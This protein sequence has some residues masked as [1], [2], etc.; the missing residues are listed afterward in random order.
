[1]SETFRC[2]DKEML[3]AY[4]YGEIDADG[5]REV[6]RH[7]RSC[8]TCAQEL[9]GLQ[10][11]R[12]DLEGWQPPQADLGFTIV[13]KP[14][15]M[16]RPSRWSSIG[17]MPAWAQAA[18]AVLVLAVGAAVA[19]IQVRYGTDGVTVTTG[20][21]RAP[22]TPA[23][24]LQAAPVPTEDWRPALAA[25]GSEL[26]G[27]IARMQRTGARQPVAVRTAVPTALSD[28]AILKRVQALLD[29]SEQRQRQEFALR[30]S[31][32]RREV[33]MNRQADLMRIDRSFGNLQGQTFKV[34]EGQRE[35]MNYFRR[36][37]TRPIP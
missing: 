34:E 1:M 35:V 28:A 9:D 37:A 4:L 16:L 24:P 30:L 22:T 10:A 2:D 33:D 19:N 25:L 6:E 20:W 11:V 15:S 31:Q 21:R 23:T 26:R 13:Q 17:N 5:C 8:A 14:A 29:E 7:L 36:V 32:V 27:E 18:A 3:V 12:R